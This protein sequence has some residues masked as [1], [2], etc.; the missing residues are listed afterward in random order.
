MPWYPR[1]NPVVSV[2]TEETF[3]LAREVKKITP[4]MIACVLCYGKGE[5]EDYKTGNVR[6]CAGCRG[7]GKM[8]NP[9]HKYQHA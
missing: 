1:R 9:K 8:K 4:L 7:T 6:K 5:K 3:R 2:S